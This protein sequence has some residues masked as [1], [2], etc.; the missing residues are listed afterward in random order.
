MLATV[1]DVEST[2]RL[3]KRSQHAMSLQRLVTVPGGAVATTVT[4]AGPPIALI[5]GGT[6][7]AAYDWEFVL[8]PLSLAN[9]VVSMDMRGHGY[10]AQGDGS[11]GIVRYW[12]DVA[13]VMNR[14]GFP[15]FSVIG[16]SMGANSGLL[17]AMTQPRLVR[18]LV[19][20][21][22]SVESYPERV[23]EILT[24]PWPRELRGLEHPASCEAD[25]HWEW[26][27]AQ[28]ALDWVD[29]VAF[30]PE[31][32]SR[33]ECPLLAVH[34]AD[35]VITDP[36]QARRVVDGVTGARAVFVPD[37]G[38]A[39]QRDQPAAFLEEVLPFLAGS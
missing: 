30:G 6:G 27:R 25:D 26:L 4:G 8:E 9:T 18:R 32:L 1:Y 36:G 24:G 10:T 14:L 29:N 2:K 7:T 15:S 22:A 19:T 16:F 13:A 17:M 35:D 21:G 34:G 23:D 5:H 39:V 12:L 38:H 31:R 3:V 28:L 37:A 33:I 11:I 20:I